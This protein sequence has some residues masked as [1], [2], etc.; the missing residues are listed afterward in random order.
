MEQ[1]EIEGYQGDA[2]GSLIGR[3]PNELLVSIT[4]PLGVDMKPDHFTVH[5]LMSN[6]LPGKVIEVR[7]YAFGGCGLVLTQQW[8]DRDP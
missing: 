5:P 7:M 3:Q 1:F 2:A 8:R 6:L 4:N